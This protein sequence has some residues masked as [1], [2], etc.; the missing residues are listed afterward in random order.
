MMAASAL[1]TAGLLAAIT[2]EVGVRPDRLIGVLARWT[3]FSFHA[4][5]VVPMAIRGYVYTA[6]T[7]RRD[8]RKTVHEGAGTR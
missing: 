2:A 1:L 7:G 8:W 6:V 4:L 3:L 5:V